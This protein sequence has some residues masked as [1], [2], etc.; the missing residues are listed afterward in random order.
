MKYLNFF[1]RIVVYWHSLHIKNIYKCEY[2]K[3]IIEYV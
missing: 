3:K 2:T 1:D